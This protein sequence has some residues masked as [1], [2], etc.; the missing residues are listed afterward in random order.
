MAARSNPRPGICAFSV[1]AMTMP[2]I[3]SIETE[4]TAKNT[5]FQTARHHCGSILKNARE[6]RVT[7]VGAQAAPLRG[8]AS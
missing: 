7:T 2:S 8:A 4:T 5:V 1:S 3:V 6:F